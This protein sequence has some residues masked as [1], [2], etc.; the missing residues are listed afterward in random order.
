M[1]RP[2]TGT[3]TTIVSDVLANLAF[4]FTDGDDANG[5]G[6]LETERVWHT[7]VSYYGP[8]A[9]TLC[10]T[11]PQAFAELLATNLLGLD[12]DDPDLPARAEDAVKEFMNILCGQ[13]ITTVHGSEDVFNLSIPSVEHDGSGPLN[14]ERG[15]ATEVLCV[16]GIP[17]RLI[18][19]AVD[20]AGTGKSP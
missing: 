7:R 17:L 5:A 16:E 1:A 19:W 8:C 18:W 11:S 20:L 9:G 2:N 15:V 4:L 3:L 10:L 6:T 13:F 12:R 14:T